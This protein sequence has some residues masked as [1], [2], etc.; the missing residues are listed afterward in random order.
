[1]FFYLL[2][3]FVLM[4]IIEL[5]LLIRLAKAI[6]LGPTL[7]IVILTGIVGA[8]LARAQGVS[9]WNKVQRDLA[10][11]RMPTS[12]IVDALL[13]FIAGVVLITPGLI[14]DVI[15]FTLLIPPARKIFKA[16]LASHFQSRMVFIH[17]GA[18]DPYTAAD[19]F[20]DVQATS[21]HDAN[22]PPGHA[23]QGDSR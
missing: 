8:A 16:K 22:P 7:G 13:I 14:T 4:P 19:D 15:G 10:D 20:I 3:L 12:E 18:T 23:L 17:P 2:L 5:S 9:A 21:A 11:G 1:M 6:S